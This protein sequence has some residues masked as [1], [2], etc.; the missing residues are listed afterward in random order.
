[1]GVIS[2]FTS[3]MCYRALQML[4]VSSH[5]HHQL[6]PTPGGLLTTSISIYHVTL[7]ACRNIENN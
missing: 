5:H 4:H 6:D 3:N 1:M 2:L 7:T